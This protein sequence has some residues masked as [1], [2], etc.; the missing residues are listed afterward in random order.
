MVDLRARGRRPYLID[1]RYASGPLAAIGF[2]AASTELAR[3]LA[4]RDIRPSHLFLGTRSGTT[5]AGLVLGAA[6]LGLPY[7]VVG[8]SVQQPAERMV[9]RIAEKITG[10]AALLDLETPA[11]ASAITVDND[12]IG[13][14]YGVPTGTG[15]E[16]LKLLARCE[17]ILADPVYTGKGLSGLIGWI[18]DGRLSS[19]DTVIFLH[20]GGAPGLF[21]QGPAIARALREG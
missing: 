13:E 14:A 18:R 8:I 4:E 5:Q 17:G 12:Y 2:V 9:P 1:M 19:R 15:T 20:T 11:A 6:L 10:A 21:A 16:A 3:Q 7:R